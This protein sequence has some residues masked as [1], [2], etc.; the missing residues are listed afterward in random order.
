MK[1]VVIV[2]DFEGELSVELTNN[3]KYVFE[4]KII[5]ENCY[6]NNMD[7]DHI[8]DGDTILF[9]L[10]NRVAKA[11]K[12]IKNLDKVIVVSRTILEEE[13]LK[14]L[15]IPQ[16]SEVLVVNDYYETTLQVTTLLYKLKIKDLRFISYKEGE[17]YRHIKYAITVGIKEKVPSSIPNI[18]DVG[19]RCLDTSTF[20]AIINKLNIKDS[21][22]NNRLLKYIKRIVTLDVGFKQQYK[23][24]YKLNEQL[25]SILEKSSDGIILIDN[26]GNIIL[27]NDRLYEILNIDMANN[28]T[29]I[30]EIFDEDFI[31]KI[32]IEDIDNELVK[33]N[34]K[35]LI[36][37][38]KTPTVYHHAVNEKIIV[39]QDITYI[40]KLEQTVSAK[41]KSTGLM[42]KYTFKKIIYYSKIMEECVETAKIFAGTDK[43]VLICGES[44]TGKE[45]LAQSIHN[46]SR[47]KKQPFVAINC[48]ALPASLLESELFG[49]AKGAFTGARSEGKSGLFEEA[50]NGSIFLDEIGDMP[51]ELQ[52][53]LLRVIQ[54]MQVMRIGSYKIIE[55]DVR[56]IAATNKNLMREVEEGRFRE[57]L[58]YRLNVLP[59]NVPPLNKRREDILPLFKKYANEHGELK[60]SIQKA[61]LEHKWRGNVRE[62]KNVAEYYSFMK[63]SPKPLPDTFII[64]GDLKIRDNL[65]IS[66]L[67][68]INKH[69]DDGDGIGRVKLVHVYNENNNKHIT[70]Y[71]L[72][73]ILKNLEEKGYISKKIG[74][75]GCVITQ[76]GLKLINDRDK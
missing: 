20:I 5:I 25:H 6:L 12:N 72:R 46:S 56:I 55:I 70:E 49:Y 67:K 44:G 3:L 36:I 34:K 65:E 52:S 74:R 21:E 75:K 63:N 48:A 11:T 73:I 50:N 13:A 51:Y 41:L 43:T 38:V 27:N 19:V 1:K 32:K 31:E 58:Y 59:L 45:L 22:I 62:L 39:L 29:N 47:R 53:R 18:I 10:E 66:V 16:N 17:D 26:D 57:D 35:I 68:A 24:L 23:E 61:L 40:K 2:T 64:K 4:D 14:I 42:A 9:M 15:D 8:I 76:K 37:S 54:E 28:M 71:R 30:N 69:A 60:E 7:D 33:I